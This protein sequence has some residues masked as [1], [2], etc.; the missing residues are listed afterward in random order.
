MIASDSVVAHDMVSLAWLL[1]NR[2]HISSSEKEGLKDP[3]NYQ[4]AVT[5]RQSLG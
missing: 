1:E 4:L 3:Y 2:N 5:Y